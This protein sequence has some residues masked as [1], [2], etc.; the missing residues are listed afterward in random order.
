MRLAPG[1]Q[2]PAWVDA[3]DAACFGDAWGALDD[4]EYLWADE[5]TGFARWR[6]IEAVGEAELLRVAVLP[7][8]RRGGRGR[9]LLRHCEGELARMGVETLHL[10]VRVSNAPARGLYESEGWRSAGTRKGY[11]RDGEDA[12][13]YLKERV[14]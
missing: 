4:S 11:Y 9:A 10:E 2:V 13:L 1:S 7:Q 5:G 12:A 8:A 14:P 3:L 6:V